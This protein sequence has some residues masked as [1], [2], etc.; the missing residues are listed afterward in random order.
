MIK[1]IGKQIVYSDGRVWSKWSKSW[2]KPQLTKKGYHKLKIN[3]KVSYLHRII[4]EAFLPNPDNLPQI[5]HISGRKTENNVNNLRWCT[6]EE[7]IKAYL[8]KR[9]KPTKSS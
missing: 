3:G 1:D 8:E 6:E 2:I 7:N 5:D 4:A 9:N